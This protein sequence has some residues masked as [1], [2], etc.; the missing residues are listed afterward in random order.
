MASLV[1][2]GILPLLCALQ[3]L[4]SALSAILHVFCELNCSG[5]V[6]VSLK[7]KKFDGC[8]P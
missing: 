8:W 5:L 4:D 7:L 1:S 2:I 6:R 3:A